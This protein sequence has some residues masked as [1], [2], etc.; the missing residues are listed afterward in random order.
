MYVQYM[1]MYVYFNEWRSNRVCMYVYSHY[2]LCINCMYMNESKY[3]LYICLYV[4]AYAYACVQ[5]YVC[6]YVCMFVCMHA[7]MLSPNQSFFGRNFHA[8]RLSSK[9]F[10]QNIV[11]HQICFNLQSKH[12]VCQNS[13]IHTLKSCV[14]T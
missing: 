7:F 14:Y 11:R 10:D 5:M 6:M 9:F 2:D 1:R 13:A 4:H 8:L 12:F 3:G